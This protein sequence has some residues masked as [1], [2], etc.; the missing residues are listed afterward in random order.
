[1]SRNPARVAAGC[2]LVLA[3]VC[4]LGAVLAR[5]SL[6]SVTVHGSSMEPTY[7][8]GDRVLVRRGATPAPGHVVVAPLPTFTPG[9]A[10]GPPTRVV[11]TADHEGWLIKRVAS[12]PGD[13]V[14]GGRVPPGRVI[15]LGDN[16]ANS[17][18]SRQIG[19]FPADAL[20]GV[21]LRRLPRVSR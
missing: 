14:P 6:V 15:L 10:E 5:R 16:S 4:C 7:R 18:D 9:D 17:L 19:Y 12:V 3:A 2:C 8:D 20:L 21:V 1:M 13:P 11:F